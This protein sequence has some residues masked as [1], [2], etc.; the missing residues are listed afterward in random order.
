[1]LL[2][3]LR[4]IE[5]R[6]L[7]LILCGMFFAHSE[8]YAQIGFLEPYCKNLGLGFCAGNLLKEEAVEQKE[9]QRPITESER[10]VLTRLI[11][12]EKQLKA[13]E[14]VLARKQKQLKALEEDL[15]KQITQLENLQK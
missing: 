3:L 5:F 13:K 8:I 12:K 6:T 10:Q 1:M 4:I 14:S 11:E 2:K 15:Q 9:V 7:L